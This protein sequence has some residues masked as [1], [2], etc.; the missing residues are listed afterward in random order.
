[1]KPVILHHTAEWLP[2]SM[3]WLLRQL[4]DT[5][6]LVENHV[7]A[8]VRHAA[9]SP[10]RH[11]LALLAEQNPMRL[12]VGGWVRRFSGAHLHPVWWAHAR[13]LRP[14][15]WMSHFG[16]TGALAAPTAAALGIPQVVRFYG[17][18]LARIPN[19]A[20][21]WRKEYDRMFAGSATY[22]AEGPYMAGTIARLGAD[23]SRIRVLPLGIDTDRI[24]FTPSDWTGGPLRVL[25]ASAYRE[26]KGIP[27]ALHALRRLG[28]D[29]DLRVTLV[30][31]PTGPGDQAEAERIRAA[32]FPGVVETGWQTPEQLDALMAAHHLY[33][34]PS[35]TAAD[36]DT[37]GGAPVSL[38]EAAAA[39]CLCIGTRHADIPFV[40]RDGETGFLAD[41]ADPESLLQAMRRA[42]E[43][44]PRWTRMRETARADMETR[45]HHRTQALA[46]VDYWHQV[47]LP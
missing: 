23:P 4:E 14:S 12:R 17:M 27:D 11:R 43:A 45:F 35:R 15:V 2:A 42:V 3:T 28:E 31:G 8:D 44:A 29:I 6:P 5:D 24:R 47:G 30:G 25:I 38:I 26:K 32:L 16:H 7:M 19:S 33:L 21:R 39:G 22:L 41:E 40:I 18:D 20:P 37:E 1:M 9:R 10:E 13:G 34:A 46:L 36:G